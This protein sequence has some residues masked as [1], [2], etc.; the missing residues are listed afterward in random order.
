MNTEVPLS[1]PLTPL[2]HRLSVAYTRATRILALI[3]VTANSYSLDGSVDEV[4]MGLLM[5]LANESCFD[6]G[7]LMDDE[8]QEEVPF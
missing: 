7:K 8:R 5:N 1:T 4:L 3:A 2:Q 6:L